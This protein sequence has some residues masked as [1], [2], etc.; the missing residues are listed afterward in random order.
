M[1]CAIF[2]YTSEYECLY[3]PFS[4]KIQL[5]MF[6]LN[7]ETAIIDMVKNNNTIKKV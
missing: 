2:Y 3:G 7:G 6:Y 4:P 1:K 5:R